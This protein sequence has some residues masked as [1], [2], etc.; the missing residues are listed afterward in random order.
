MLAFIDARIAYRE[1]S[2]QPIL[3]VIPLFT[4]YAH[5]SRRFGLKEQMKRFK[6]AA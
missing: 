2:R 6:V 5:L 3:I 1:A 4:V